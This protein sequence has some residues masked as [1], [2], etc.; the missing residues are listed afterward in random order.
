LKEI[1][2][3]KIKVNWGEGNNIKMDSSGSE[4]EDVDWIY[5]A[6]DRVN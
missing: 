3:L 5:F 6:Q 1:Y 4:E 2:N